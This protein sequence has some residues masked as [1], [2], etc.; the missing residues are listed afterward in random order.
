MRTIERKGD[1]DSMRIETIVRVQN[2]EGIFGESFTGDYIFKGFAL[3]D[4]GGEG[5]DTI[6]L[7]CVDTNKLIL[8]HSL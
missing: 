2:A 7:E 1:F 3:V 6:I 8:A 4:I 5:I